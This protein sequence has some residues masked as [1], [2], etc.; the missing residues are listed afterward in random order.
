MD[1]PNAFLENEARRINLRP[2]LAWALAVAGAVFFLSSLIEPGHHVGLFG[3]DAVAH[4]RLLASHCDSFPGFGENRLD[5][6]FAP[7]GVA[8]GLMND[9]PLM[10]GLAC[11]WPTKNPTARFHFYAALQWIFLWAVLI[12]WARRYLQNWGPA[13]AFVMAI[14]FGA[15][16]QVRS[17]G[18]YN[19]FP[20]AWGGFALW[21][22]LWDPL[23]LDWRKLLPRGLLATLVFLTSI[24]TLPTFAILFIVLIL[25]QLGIH[26]ARRQLLLRTLALLPA[27][28]A[29]AAFF[30]AP[31]I[32]AARESN[33]RQDLS[34]AGRAIFNADLLSYLIPGPFS[35]VFQQSTSLLGELYPVQQGL[36]E[37]LNSFE[38][39]VLLLLPF[40]VIERARLRPYLKWLLPLA[41]V[42]FVLSLGSQIRFGNVVL[43][44]NPAFNWLSSLP[45]FSAS[46]TP[47]RYATVAIGLVT[48]LT[49][50][51]L[52]GWWSRRQFK[53]GI[54]TAVSLI[55]VALTMAGVGLFSPRSIRAYVEDYRP[56][57]PEAGLTQLRTEAGTGYAVQLP[58]ALMADPTQNFL[59]GFHGRKLI[60][61]YVSYTLMTEETLAYINTHPV[62]LALDCGP[63]PQIDYTRANASPENFAQLTRELTT[64]LKAARVDVVILNWSLLAQPACREL[65]EYFMRAK[66]QT[67]FEIIE[68]KGRYSVLR[69]R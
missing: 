53:R 69:L 55:L 11:L 33:L 64:A 20:L 59:Q 57:I 68:E 18:H 19:L 30:M 5:Y 32:R 26:P 12:L 65:G 39:V 37:N 47:G 41:G 56:L 22:L 52:D 7:K 45:P 17:L 35:P 60:N 66:T 29:L 4:S 1:K 15:F 34:E 38:F 51:G 10:S 2:K 44:D 58:L 36:L 21:L 61:G 67:P 13:V 28:L 23:P 14:S 46:R 6:L 62:F 43:F 48:A 24:Q 42:Y 16:I 49:F 9:S 25:R 54:A 8:A 40:V 50:L 3:Q 31:L 27:A 63:T